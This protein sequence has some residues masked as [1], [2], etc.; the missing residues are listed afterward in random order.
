MTKI[1]PVV[2]SGGMGSRLWP[3]SRIR[4]PKQ[5][6]P[7]HGSGGPTFLQVTIE[8]H[9]GA[10]YHDPIIVANE[11]QLD[12][13]SRQIAQIDCTA[14]MIGEPEGRNTGPAV[15]AAALEI[16]A[17]EPGGLMLV[18]PSDHIIHGDLDATIAAIR[19]AALDGRIVVFGVPP[20]SPETGFGYI[21]D[22]G[23]VS[24][25][26]GLHEVEGFIEKPPLDRA[27]A[28]LDGG[29]AFW[30]SGISL[31]RSDVIIAEF[32]RFAP[33][34]LR[35]V[36]AAIAAGKWFGPSLLMDRDA[37]TGAADAPTEK[38][39]FER[40]AAVALAPLDV[41][42]NDVGAWSAI[43]SIGQ[44]DD[45]GN[46]ESGQIVSLNNRNSLIR[47]DGKLI[48]VIGMENVIVIDTPDALLVTNH[49]N[50]QDVK[51]VVNM[52]RAEAR[53]E[54]ETHMIKQVAPAPTSADALAEPTRR[55]E[56]SPGES[57]E[58]KG[59]GQDG[60][61]CTVAVGAATLVIEGSERDLS[62]GQTFYLLAGEQAVA[63]ALGAS[64]ATLVMVDI[65]Q[66]PTRGAE[67]E[68]R[69]AQAGRRPFGGA[70]WPPETPPTGLPRMDS[71][72]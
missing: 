1:N 47:G 57:R 10:M 39:I 3:M 52:L 29:R 46:V 64:G 45:D 69:M 12:L 56:I 33:E 8:R 14:R 26:P 32:A 15:L 17:R 66:R 35:A 21:V 59:L 36:Q 61:V 49:D 50:A 53:R 62:A 65:G 13:I 41:D 30:A 72:V 20:R 68:Y 34:T 19:A 58:L 55:Y 28:L 37:F 5:F 6:Q 24:H 38:L 67:A 2:L 40:S 11:S 25:F 31:F 7:V 9:R 70:A 22:G 16:E 63:R 48:A 71:V 43:Y 51:T 54:V 42:W 27:Q 60:T 4:Q 44:K 18:L 23:A